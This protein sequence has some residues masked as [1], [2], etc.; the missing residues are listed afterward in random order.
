MWKMCDS[1]TLDV[2]QIKGL[3]FDIDGT[4]RDTDD[5]FVEKLS[6]YLNPISRVMSGY[7]SKVAA[8]KIV[9][10]MESPAT[11]LF[12]LPDR[13]GVDHY[14]VRF[15]DFI[16]QSG[17]KNEKGDHPIIEGVIEMISFLSGYYPMS[18]VSNRDEKS[19]K[20]FIDT[21]DLADKFHVVV[22]GQTCRYGK[23]S[24]EPVLYA[25]EKMGVPAENCLM[26]GDTTVDIK[27]AKGVGA[28]SVGV[29]CGFGEREE[30]KKQGA[31]LILDNPIELMDLLLPGKDLS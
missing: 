5:Q 17:N 18:I 10:L 2:K 4:L 27:A 6:R 8:R 9:M 28:Q 7:S 26:I 14:V 1:M 13:F 3:C 24:P 20:S 30:L 29:L 12:G 16:H 25:A 15:L 11:Y 22:T 19:T 21:Y 31:N 23:P